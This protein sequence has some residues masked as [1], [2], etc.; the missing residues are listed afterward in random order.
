MAAFL[1]GKGANVDAVGSVCTASFPLTSPLLPCS[2]LHSL[3]PYCTSFLLS[4]LI[5][6]L[7]MYLQRNKLLLL[8]TIIYQDGDTPLHWAARGA[9]DT[10]KLLIENGAHVNATNNV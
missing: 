1:I 2:L 9:L 7:S 8:I 6:S 10:A 3:Y 4:M 5:I